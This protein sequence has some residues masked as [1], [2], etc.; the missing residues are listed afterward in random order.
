MIAMETYTNTF[1]EGLREGAQQSA[2][3]IV[4]LVLQLLHPRRVVDVGCGWGNWLAVFREH[5]IDE[6]WGIDGE[7]VDRTKLQ[8]PPERFLARDLTGPFELGRRFDLVV[9]LEVA[10]HLPAECAADFVRSLTC[11]GP[12]VLFSA[13]IPH[14]GGANHVNE[15]WPDYWAALFEERGYVPVDCL[16]RKVWDN[17][18]VD[19]WYAQ[20]MLLFAAR[21]ALEAYPLLQREYE[22]AGSTPLSLV[23]PRKY[24]ECV[25]WGVKQCEARWKDE[26]R[27]APGME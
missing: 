6:I 13:A 24:L 19:W 3:V 11:L 27:A 2:R 10:E 17:D 23:H 4:P 9:S 16:R 15:Q 21:E 7:Y 26:P 1:F 8:I 12:L 18:R 14:Q 5:G 25:E 22:R 20:N